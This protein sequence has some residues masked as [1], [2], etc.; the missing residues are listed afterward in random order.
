MWQ[1]RGREGEGKKGEREGGWRERDRGGRENMRWLCRD[2]KDI[3]DSNCTDGCIKL[4]EVY[5]SIQSQVVLS[6]Q[7]NNLHVDNQRNNTSYLHR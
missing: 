6:I 2:N 7:C 4:P 3:I 5:Y 1:E